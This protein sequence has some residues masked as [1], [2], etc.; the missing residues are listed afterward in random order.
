MI[1]PVARAARIIGGELPAQERVFRGLLVG[2]GAAIVHAIVVVVPHC[3]MGMAVRKRAKLLLAASHVGR[4][5]LG[6]VKRLFTRVHV[7]T[8]KHEEVWLLGEH[9]V[10]DRLRPALVGSE[11]TDAYAWRSPLATRRGPLVVAHHLRPQRPRSRRRGR[12]GI[13]GQRWGG[14][15]SVRHTRP[16]PDG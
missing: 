16:L 4:V 10:P 12:Q 8:G 2:T 15:A 14:P 6:D 7:V 11:A 3:Q 1:Q 9:G 13:R 5:E